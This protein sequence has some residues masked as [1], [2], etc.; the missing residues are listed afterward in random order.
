MVCTGNEV[1]MGD[2][3][4]LPARSFRQRKPRAIS[5]RNGDK[6]SR[7]GKATVSPFLGRKGESMI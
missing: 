5:E 1:M 6:G 3:G 4:N 2:S 7:D